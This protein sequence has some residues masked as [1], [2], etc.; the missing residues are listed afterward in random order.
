MQNQNIIFG[1]DSYLRV[2]PIAVNYFEQG[3]RC[4]IDTSSSLG[5]QWL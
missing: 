3:K 4:E 2:F 1:F 5:T